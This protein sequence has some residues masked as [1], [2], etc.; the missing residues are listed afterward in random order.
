MVLDSARFFAAAAVCAILGSFV[1]ESRAS[2][3]SVCT[4]VAV[5]ICHSFFFEFCFRFFCFLFFL[6]SIVGSYLVFSFL[7]SLR[8]LSTMIDEK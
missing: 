7:L 3:W 6:V 4:K 5:V 1:G 2:Y 8:Y